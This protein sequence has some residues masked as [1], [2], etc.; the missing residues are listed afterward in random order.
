MT[1]WP[2]DGVPLSATQFVAQEL[3]AQH[4]LH[5]ELEI[6]HEHVGG[7]LGRGG[8]GARQHDGGED[9]RLLFVG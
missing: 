1:K 3:P 6:V 9:G 8:A 5:L 4:L 2:S 7:A